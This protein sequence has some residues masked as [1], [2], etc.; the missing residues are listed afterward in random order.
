MPSAG[1]DAALAEAAPGE[2]N[3]LGYSEVHVE[4]GPVLEKLALPVGVVTG[5]M[6]ESRVEIEFLGE[7]AQVGII[8]MTERKDALFAAELVLAAEET[9]HKEPGMIATVGKVSVYP[10]AHDVIPGAARL[11]LDLHH[12]DDSVREG[13]LL[14]LRD[15]AEAIA[16]SRGAVMRWHV[17]QER[18]AVPADPK[19]TTL[20]ARAVE[21]VGYPV[22]RLPSGAGHDAAAMAEIAPIAMLLVRYRGGISHNPARS[23]E[24]ED[25]AVAI[26]VTSRILELLAEAPRR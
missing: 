1:P 17:H 23:V 18:R 7:S 2:T 26:E 16:A 21:E 11:S 12:E 5:T 4:Q 8:P 3:L 20:L 22:E 13:A 19:L 9:A 14:S 15:G 10:N 25:V 24:P 6:G